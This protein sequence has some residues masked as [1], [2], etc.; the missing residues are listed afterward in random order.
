M[1]RAPLKT[2]VSWHSSL[3]HL[4]ILH[5][6]KTLIMQKWYIYSFKSTLKTRSRNLVALMGPSLFKMDLGK[7]NKLK[8]KIAFGYCGGCLLRDEKRRGH[9]GCYLRMYNIM[10]ASVIVWGCISENGYLAHL[11]RRHY[12]WVIYTGFW[13]HICSHQDNILF[14]AGL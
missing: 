5:H 8:N 4:Q 12:D 6:A 3:L 14:I 11:W 10:Q 9:P 13:S 2:F 7:F 1:L